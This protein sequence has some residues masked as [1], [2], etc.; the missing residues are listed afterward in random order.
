[1]AKTRSFSIFLLKRAFTPANVLEPDHGLDPVTD[2]TA[3]PDGS[4]LYILDSKP[5]EPWWRGFFGI[6]QPLEQVGK[7]A[8]VFIPREGR[9]FALSF[10]HVSHNMKPEGYEYDFGL[11]VTLNSVDR[12]ALK[13]TDILEPGSARRRRIQIPTAA[14]LTLFDVDNDGSILRSLTG[15]VKA[16]RLHLFKNATGASSLRISAKLSTDEMSNLCGEL[17]AIYLS[18]EYKAIF[19]DVQSVSPINDPA[20]VSQLDHKLLQALRRKSDSISLAVP[21]IINY[22]ESLSVS[23]SGQGPSQLYDGADIENFY[24]YLEERAKKPSSITLADVERYKMLLVNDDSHDREAFPFYKSLIFDT[25]LPGN[26]GVYHLVEGNWYRFDKSYINRMREYL[27]PLFVTDAQLPSFS[28]ATEGEYNSAVAASLPDTLCL[29]T[30]NIS[31]KS[32]TPVEPCDIYSVEGGRALLRHVK[33]STRSSQ[34]SHLFNQGAVSV[35]LL[36]V[37]PAASINL[38]NLVRA[39]GGSATASLLAP[40]LSEEYAVRYCIITTR[41]ETKK[42]DNLPLFSRM[43]LMRTAKALKLMGV[44]RSICFVEDLS[45]ASPKKKP[46]RKKSS[47]P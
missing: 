40:I 37:E 19:P 28:Q 38:Q 16:S 3:L 10:G 31:P 36:K 17:L 14:D 13:S 42:S 20:V 4:L 46:T 2:A 11:R 18:D 47:A 32:Y 45:V 12:G 39:A 1:M 8:L 27:D 15:K 25:N 29:D 23:F 41:D 35:E 30:T 22:N 26:G 7:G 6:P 34:L 24:D 21:S 44:H 33:I 43:T 9:W 5:R